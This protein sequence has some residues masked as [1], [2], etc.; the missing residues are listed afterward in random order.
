MNATHVIRRPRFAAIVLAIIFALPVVATLTADS[1]DAS[2]WVVRTGA[3][4]IQYCES[5]GQADC[6]IT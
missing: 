2:G 1:A 4:G 6:N 5:G 3:D